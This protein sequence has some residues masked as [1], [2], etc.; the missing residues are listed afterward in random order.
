[1]TEIAVAMTVTEA[2]APRQ[3]ARGNRSARLT[4]LEYGAGTVSC[5]A[6]TAKASLRRRLLRSDP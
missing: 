2:Q 5:R 3:R 4:P 6:A 1:M